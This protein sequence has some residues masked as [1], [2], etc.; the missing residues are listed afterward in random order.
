VV[1]GA[2]GPG[3]VSRLWQLFLCRVSLLCFNLQGDNKCLRR[4]YK[5]IDSVE[6]TLPCGAGYVMLYILNMFLMY[7]MSSVFVDVVKCKIAAC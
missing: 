3:F 2:R 6:R 5:C 4:I 7:E 1:R